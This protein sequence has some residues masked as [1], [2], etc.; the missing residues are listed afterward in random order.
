[1]ALREI[2]LQQLLLLGA[3]ILAASEP[4][5]ICNRTCG[6]LHI[7]YPFGTSEGCYLNSSF[8]ITCKD[9]TPF[10]RLSNE[11]KVLDVSLEGEIRVSSFIARDC[12]NEPGYNANNSY[13]QQLPLL[14]HFL[15]SYTKNKFIA[16]GCDTVPVITGALAEAESYAAGCFS[17]SDSF[18][19]VDNGSCTGIGCC[20]TFSQK[21]M[22]SFV[23]TAGSLLNDHSAVG[24]FNPCS[25]FSFVAEEKAY[26]FLQNRQTVPAVLDWA[27]GNETCPDARKDLTSH[28]CK[29][30]NSERYSSTNGPGYG[31]KGNDIH[32]VA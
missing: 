32:L 28:A 15:I 31:C 13:Y 12:P 5:S 22:S 9:S 20:Q 8:L 11:V 6:S 30:A 29:A 16:V 17:L 14:K 2:L 10:L 19:I 4:Y 21:E 3:I 26:N 24:N 25:N 27:V 7:P 23:V 1:M 18:H